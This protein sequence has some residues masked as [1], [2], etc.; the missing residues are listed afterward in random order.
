MTSVAQSGCE[1]DSAAPVFLVNLSKMSA[2]L[3]SSA[4]LPCC[5][6]LDPKEA[7]HRCLR[8][9]FC[10]Q[11]IKCVFTENLFCCVSFTSLFL[12][13]QIL[14]KVSPN[15]AFIHSLSRY[16]VSTEIMLVK[17]K[18]KETENHP[19]VVKEKMRIEGDVH[20]T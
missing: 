12:H 19:V 14:V 7:S 3:D 5:V 11:T 9:C 8:C 18:W 20:S 15:M 10:Y 1:C 13:A 4:C 2:M 6:L 16:E 17:L